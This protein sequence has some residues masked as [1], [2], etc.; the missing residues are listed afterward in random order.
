MNCGD[1]DYARLFAGDGEHGDKGVDLG[2]D[3]NIDESDE[4][5]MIDRD[6]FGKSKG[7]SPSE[8]DS[9]GEGKVASVGKS[10]GDD[11]D[12]ILSHEK[13]RRQKL[14]EKWMDVVKGDKAPRTILRS[15]LDLLHET[16]HTKDTVTVLIERLVN[17]ELEPAKT[18]RKSKRKKKGASITRFFEEEAEIGDDKGGCDERE[19]SEDMEYS[20]NEPGNSDDDGFENCVLTSDRPEDIVYICPK[21]GKGIKGDAGRNLICGKKGAPKTSNVFKG[22]GS[23]IRKWKLDCTHEAISARR[24][25][26]ISALRT[27]KVAIT[28][29]QNLSII[30]ELAVKELKAQVKQGK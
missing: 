18:K 5:N 17:A 29:S 30:D 24:E 4:D 21:T 7:K 19:N 15:E 9:E 16:W 12:E 26:L 28:E 3:A 2:I 1:C 10:D 25:E 13:L 20:F 14:T 6:A 8:I 23:R 22:I 27:I 11:E